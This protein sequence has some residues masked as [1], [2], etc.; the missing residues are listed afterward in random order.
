MDPPLPPR[1]N[2]FPQR[3]NQ[4]VGYFLREIPEFVWPLNTPAPQ[5]VFQRLNHFNYAWLQRRWPGVT[6]RRWQE[7]MHM[8]TAAITN[9]IDVLRRVVERPLTSFARH[10]AALPFQTVDDNVFLEATQVCANIS[11]VD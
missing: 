11:G 6:H 10:A 9:R 7:L 5:D 3:D 4:W 8:A 1:R 2:P